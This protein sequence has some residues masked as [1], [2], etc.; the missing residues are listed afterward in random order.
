LSL[1]IVSAFKD[2]NTASR[3]GVC[4]LGSIEPVMNLEND[5]TITSTGG[6]RICRAHRH[7]PGEPRTSDLAA[8]Q[9]A[10]IRA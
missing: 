10:W 6:E 3:S 2:H 4:R 8:C 1:H 9:A 7:G 5:V